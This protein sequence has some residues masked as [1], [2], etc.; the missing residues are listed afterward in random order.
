[1]ITIILLTFLAIA[2]I[3]GFYIWDRAN[4]DENI[5]QYRSRL[6]ALKLASHLNVIIQCDIRVGKSSNQVVEDLLSFENITPRQKKL[7]EALH[8]S[9]NTIKGLESVYQNSDAIIKSS[10]DPLQCDVHF[11]L[12]KTPKFMKFHKAKLQ[13][14]D[15]DINK[16]IDDLNKKKNEN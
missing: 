6:G 7:I 12:K 1:M 16:L 10:L 3:A 14:L 9:D 5:Y 11:H 8:Q 15:D 4:L 13:E 2:T